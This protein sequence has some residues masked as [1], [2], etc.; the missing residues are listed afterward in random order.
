MQVSI[1]VNLGTFAADVQAEM[2][3]LQRSV[4]R[5]IQSAGLM[6]L[7]LAQDACPVDSGNLKASLHYERGDMT[8]SV[9]TAVKYAPYV[10]LGHHTHS[11][12]WVP[13]QPFLFPAYQQASKKLQEQCIKK[14]S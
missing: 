12:S 10:E 6:C 4:N 3:K 9:G 1:E 8:C 13:A 2:K 5:D 14:Y 7:S 11:G